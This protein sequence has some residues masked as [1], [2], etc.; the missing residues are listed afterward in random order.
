M[1]SPV[2]LMMFPASRFLPTIPET[3]ELIVFAVACTIGLYYFQIRALNAI[4]AFTVNLSYNLEP[5]YSI[6]LAILI[7]HEHREFSAAF[8]GCLFLLVLSVSLQSIR[9]WRERKKASEGV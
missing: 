4:S 6:L 2:W 8:C 7:F 1:S 3:G 5:V 9:Q